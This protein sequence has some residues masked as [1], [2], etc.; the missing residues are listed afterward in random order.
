MIDIDILRSMITR[1]EGKRYKIY[2][3]ANPNEEI[4]P[5]YTLKGYITVGVGHNL[6]EPM[7]DDII[8][9][10]LENDISNAISDCASIYPNW[11]ELPDNAQMVLIDMCFNMGKRGLQNFKKMN[12]AV[13]DFNWA[14]MVKEMADSK[15][16]HQVGV[17]ASE[18]REMIETLKG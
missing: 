5:G 12:R 13:E 14:T 1:H 9:D 16:A 4:K 17:R 6:H 8:N 7:T 11:H 18:L 15:W 2:D 3:D 10:L